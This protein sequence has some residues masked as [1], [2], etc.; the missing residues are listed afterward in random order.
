MKAKEEKQLDRRYMAWAN[1][2]P[3][4]NE[5]NFI[6]FENFCNGKVQQ[7]ETQRPAE[8]ILKMAEATK[9]QIEAG[10]CKIQ[11]GKDLRDEKEVRALYN[12]SKRK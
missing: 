6:S 4:F 2:Y 1:C 9:M 5:S 8:D 3:H 12:R 7:P 10:A 11:E